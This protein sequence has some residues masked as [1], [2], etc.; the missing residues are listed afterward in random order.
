MQHAFLII[1]S[2]DGTDILMA[3]LWVHA[4]VITSITSEIIACTMLVGY[5]CTMDGAT[6]TATVPKCS[7]CNHGPVP[8]RWELTCKSWLKCAVGYLDV[9]C[10]YM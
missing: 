4:H 2:L 5:R 6:V 10:D 8:S 3:S 7:G 9:Q 1:P